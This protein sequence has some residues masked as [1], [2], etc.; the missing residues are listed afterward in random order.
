MPIAVAVSGI[1]AGTASDP[2]RAKAPQM[3]AWSLRQNQAVWSSSR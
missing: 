1:R 2:E 3:S